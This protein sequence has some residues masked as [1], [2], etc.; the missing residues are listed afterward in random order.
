MS[1]AQGSPEILWSFRK[2]VKFRRGNAYHF[3]GKTADQNLRPND[4]WPTSELALP[5][6][7]AEHDDRF[8]PGC[9]RIFWK[10]RT[11]QRRADTKHLKV[12]T[13]DQFSLK[14]MTFHS[15]VQTLHR[16]DIRK[17]RFF[18]RKV[19]DTGPTRIHVRVPCGQTT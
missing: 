9:V 13:S 19:A 14:G 11:T 4:V 8:P 6:L 3:H 7:V 5:C 16:G 12:I 18:F 10:Q 17:R 1:H 15:C 2:S